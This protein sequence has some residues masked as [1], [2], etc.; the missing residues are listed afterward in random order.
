MSNEINEYV[1]DATSDPIK[2]AD[3]LDMDNEDGGGGF[4]KSKKISVLAFVTFIRGVFGL[5][6]TAFTIPRF[7]NSG[8]LVD[9]AMAE[10]EPGINI[11]NDGLGIGIEASG[12]TSLNIKGE[13]SDGSTESIYIVDS[14]DT[15]KKS[16]FAFALF[17]HASHLNINGNR[18]S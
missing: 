2:N 4:D 8:N 14:S 3:L 17:C 7:D 15:L 10:G 18:N 6:G 12:G 1:A 11:L 9:S 16:L 13:S 5:N